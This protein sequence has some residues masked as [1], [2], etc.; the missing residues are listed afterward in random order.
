[1]AAPCSYAFEK[2]DIPRDYLFSGK[3]DGRRLGHG[4]CCFLDA[5]VAGGGRGAT[6]EQKQIGLHGFTSRY[7]KALEQKPPR[8]AGWKQVVNKGR[9]LGLAI[10]PR[11]AAR[12]R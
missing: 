7:R 11:P 6:G 2:T 4:F 5:Q 1:M 3:T 8:R 9:D 12:W 10:H